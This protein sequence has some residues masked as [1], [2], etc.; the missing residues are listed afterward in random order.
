[1]ANATKTIAGRSLMT[2]WR[3][4][5][6][7]LILFFEQNFSNMSIDPRKADKK[8]KVS[9][10]KN[11][12][13]M[14]GKNQLNATSDCKSK[15]FGTGTSISIVNECPSITQQIESTQTPFKTPSLLSFGVGV[16]HIFRAFQLHD[17]HKKNLPILDF[18]FMSISS[19]Y[20]SFNSSLSSPH[21]PD[22][23][24]NEVYSVK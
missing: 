8:K 5:R 10:E 16:Y 21:I 3:Q 6:K 15:M 17:Q 20:L 11:P 1:M 12:P 7:K 9:T 13:V 19:F 14:N 18:S 4:T 24:N 23:P 22:P 2:Q